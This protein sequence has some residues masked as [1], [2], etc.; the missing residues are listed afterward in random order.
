MN[1]KCKLHVLVLIFS[2]ISFS[3]SGQEKS[4]SE[5]EQQCEDAR[6]ARIAP[7][8]EQAIEECIQSRS[9]NRETG[10][11]R[12]KCEDFYHDYGSAG[13][14]QSGTF[15]QRMFHD[16]PECQEFY[17]AERKQGH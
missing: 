4:L 15:R 3:V 5:L 6:E 12:A 9:Q 8:R 16:I 11:I 7:L 10:D 14:T 13:R 17:E 1:I 2:C